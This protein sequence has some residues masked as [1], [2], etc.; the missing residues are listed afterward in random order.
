MA[1]SYTFDSLFG[2]QNTSEIN[3]NDNKVEEIKPPD[4]K[5]LRTGTKKDLKL[6]QTNP[7]AKSSLLD[8]LILAKF[9]K[10]SNEKTEEVNLLNKKR[11]NPT[12]ISNPIFIGPIINQQ[13]YNCN[14]NPNKADS[15]QN[16]NTQLINPLNVLNKNVFDKKPIVNNIGS[17]VNFN[18]INKSDSKLNSD[19]KTINKYNTIHIPT[20]YLNILDKQPQINSF[21]KTIDDIKNFQEKRQFS[22]LLMKHN[23]ESLKNIKICS[24][25]NI[26]QYEFFMKKYLPGLAGPSYKNWLEKSFNLC[27]NNSDLEKLEFCLDLYLDDSN[28]MNAYFFK[29]NW[30][31]IHLP[32]IEKISD[33]QIKNW[34]IKRDEL[35][36]ITDIND[37]D[38]E[39][40]KNDK[41]D[42]NSNKYDKADKS[43]IT[44][45]ER[46]KA[47]IESKSSVTTYIPPTTKEIKEIRKS[48]FEE[49]EVTKKIETLTEKVIGT[50]KN[51]EKSYFR[52]SSLPDPS[53]VRPEYILKQSLALMIKKWTQNLEDY[54]YLLDQFRSIRQ[55][56]TIQNIKNDFT[57]KV[58]ETNARISLE[59]NDLDQFNQCQ[60][61]LIMLYKTNKG[62]EIEFLSYRI[63]YNALVES[64]SESLLKE[65]CFSKYK[66][67][68][69]VKN[70]LGIRKAINQ[71][72]YFNF[73]KL[74]LECPNMGKV[75]IK[76]FLS[77]IRV[78]ALLSLFVG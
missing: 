68:S 34:R 9:S 61:Q 76:P 31:G 35:C 43:D 57:V 38:D 26:Q 24:L 69:E 63:I 50:N 65:I 19:N 77:R 45:S 30:D 10:I 25:P 13:I 78:K 11:E 36:N 23:T 37:L 64:K 71:N 44:L 56:L 42:K 21:K 72:D 27:K 39:I 46:T 8:D 16:Y 4:K 55:D 52:T 12:V 29:K 48:R 40:I 54:N 1:D 41:K 7:Q 53:N 62:N 74:Y 60:S 20:N 5:K 58:Y 75:L 6:N 3:K 47:L 73:F 2:K 59:N 51:L 70:A 32:E 28:R 17:N 22:M 18:M 66:K 49:V 15:Y 67:S 33:F 14:I